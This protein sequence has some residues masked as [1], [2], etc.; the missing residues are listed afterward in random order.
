MS[1]RSW[2]IDRL[3]YPLHSDR[4]LYPL[5][6]IL[7]LFHAAGWS[8]LIR[9]LKLQVV[10]RERATNYRALLRKMTYEDKA[11]CDSTPPCSSTHTKKIP[12]DTERAS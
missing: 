4:L 1:D 2:L 7:G 11:S 6:S 3:L 8:R 9:C 10:F 5:H 12:R